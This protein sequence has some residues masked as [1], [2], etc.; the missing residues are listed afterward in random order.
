MRNEVLEP[1][2]KLSENLLG[3]QAG[4]ARAW[5]VLHVKS[6]Q[7]KALADDLDRLGIDYYLPLVRELHYYGQRKNWVDLP[8]FPGYIFL[9]GRREDMYRADRTR[10]VLQIL[11]VTDQRQFNSELE[12]IRMV[13]DNQGQLKPH[14]FLR[15]GCRVEVRSGP[16]RGLLGL[17]E[18]PSRIHRIVLQ[19]N[20]LGRA[21]S[22]EMDASLLEVI[23]M[24]ETDRVKNRGVG[25]SDAGFAYGL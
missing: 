16:F 22:M 21:V 5:H 7:E 14:P 11:T 17:V 23:A 1:G 8:L 3:R 4:Q 24:P 19:V 13:L 6:R 9:S 10:R 12:N 18:D 25:V 2:F 15:Q 20:I